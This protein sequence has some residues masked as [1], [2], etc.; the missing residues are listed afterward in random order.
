MVRDLDAELKA[1]QRL[2]SKG[3]I[4]ERV[5]DKA[6]ELANLKKERLREGLTVDGEAKP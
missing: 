4:S 3:A 6:R 2:A 1:L 5:V